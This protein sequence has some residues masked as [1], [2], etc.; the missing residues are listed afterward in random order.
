MFAHKLI[1]LIDRFEQGGGIAGR[2]VYDKF[3]VIRKHL[4][5][6]T[7]NFINSEISQLP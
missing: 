7:I 5:Q 2:D 6:E 4:K 3:K 1:A